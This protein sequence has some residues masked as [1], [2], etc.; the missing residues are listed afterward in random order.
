[1]TTCFGS[2]IKT[3]KAI[4]QNSYLKAGFSRHIFTYV[5]QILASSGLCVGS[6]LQ[7]RSASPLRRA[8]RNPRR[9]P[10]T[11]PGRQGLAHLLENAECNQVQHQHFPQ[12][13]QR[14]I[15]HEQ[16]KYINTTELSLEQHGSPDLNES[17]WIHSSGYIRRTRHRESV[18]GAGLPSSWVGIEVRSATN[19]DGF[20]NVGR[21]R[22]S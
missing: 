6:D 12:T 5:S 17:Q 8:A 11:R 7:R 19:N 15:Q 22:C 10:K 3:V 21:L 9:R 13:V 2:P 14:K 4:R 18:A 1:M 20:R 16:K